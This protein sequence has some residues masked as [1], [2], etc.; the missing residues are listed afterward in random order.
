[1]LGLFYLSV[2]FLLL[3]IK[4]FEGT[5]V[6]NHCLNVCVELCGTFDANFVLVQVEMNRTNLQWDSN[7]L[8]LGNT[9]EKNPEESESGEKSVFELEFSPMNKRKL[10]CHF[11]FV[12]G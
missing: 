10:N 9:Q 12:L 7:Q 3:M 2:S 5:V 11:Y 8:P 4:M 1:M 6:Q